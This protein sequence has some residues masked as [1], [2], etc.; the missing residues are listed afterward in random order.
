MNIQPDYNG[1]KIN[2]QKLLK[3]PYK[4]SLCCDGSW[5]CL[6]VHPWHNKFQLPTK[7]KIIQIESSLGY[8]KVIIVIE[9]IKKVHDNSLF[10]LFQACFYVV[11]TTWKNRSK[12]YYIFL[13]KLHQCNTL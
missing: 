10:G 13:Y 12:N 4:S 11:E 5:A 9:S 7:S 6:R 2:W 3:Q 8:L 1:T